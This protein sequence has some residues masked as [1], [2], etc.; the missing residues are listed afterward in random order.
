[1]TNTGSEN[2][3]ELIKLSELDITNELKTKKS[4]KRDDYLG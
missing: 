4:G 3:K 1:M 2:L